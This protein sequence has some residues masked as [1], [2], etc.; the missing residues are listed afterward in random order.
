MALYFIRRS[1][2][3]AAD[4]DPKARTEKEKVLMKEF[5]PLVVTP[6]LAPVAIVLM[7]MGAGDW[8]LYLVLGVGLILVGYS[9]RVRHEREKRERSAK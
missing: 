7:I 1:R 4:P 8:V 6:L 5:A 2:Q 9:L 3:V